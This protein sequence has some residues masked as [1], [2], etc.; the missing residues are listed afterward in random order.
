[1]QEVTG[2]IQSD[3]RRKSKDSKTGKE[4]HFRQYREAN[5]KVSKVTI[6]PKHF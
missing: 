3:P 4:T 1:M 5:K 2:T 6:V